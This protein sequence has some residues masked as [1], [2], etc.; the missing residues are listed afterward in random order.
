MVIS[1][2]TSE[3]SKYNVSEFGVLIPTTFSA[4][5]ALIPDEISNV[6]M[7]MMFFIFYFKF[8]T[9]IIK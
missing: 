6:R 1:V 3:L 4:D 5:C 8:N 2:L 9:N 7:I